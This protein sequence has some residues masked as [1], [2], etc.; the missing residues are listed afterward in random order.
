[1]ILGFEITNFDVFDYDRCGMLIEDSVAIAG[2][3]K[4]KD[5]VIRLRNLNA[6]IGRNNTG[7]TSFL[8]ALSFVKRCIMHDVASAATMDQRPGFSNLLIRKD[9]PSTFKLFFRIR[10]CHNIQ[11]T[12]CTSNHSVSA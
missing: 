7:K 11:T 9:K 3:E 4:S 8:M 12:S 6:L 2:G 1:M 10:G 5:E